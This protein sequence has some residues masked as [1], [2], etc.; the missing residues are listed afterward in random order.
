MR[1]SD[2]SSYVC[3]S[4]PDRAP[5]SVRF[6]SGGDGV[7]QHQDRSG[8][9]CRQL[10]FVLRLATAL[11]VEPAFADTQFGRLAVRLEHV[12]DR[13]CGDAGGGQRFHLD[14]GRRDGLD[15]GN[16]LDTILANLEKPVGRRERQWM[17]ERNK[18]VVMLVR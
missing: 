2:W 9:R 17:T 7:R 16:D 3:S 13:Q 8:D 10:A 4:D 14:A 18:L 6:A 11:L 5:G 12:V 1:I 15:L